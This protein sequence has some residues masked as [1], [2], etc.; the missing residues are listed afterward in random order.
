MGGSLGVERV[1]LSARMAAASWP[2]LLAP[3]RAC[4]VLSD[5][6]N[7]RNAFCGCRLS[8]MRRAAELVLVLALLACG[9]CAQGHARRL[10]DQARSSSP[11]GRAAC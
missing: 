8:K 7:C 9:G 11:A 1:R 2:Q 3:A 4:N 5:V 10:A 6:R